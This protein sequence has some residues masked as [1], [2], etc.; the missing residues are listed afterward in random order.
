[1]D[2]ERGIVLVNAPLYLDTQD[3]IL[4]V[5][6]TDDGLPHLSDEAI[7]YVKMIRNLNPPFITSNYTEQVSEYANIGHRVVRVTATDADPPNSPSGQL[8]YDLAPGLTTGA[9]D[10][11]SIGLMGEP[12][13]I[14]VNKTLKEFPG[15]DMYFQVIASDSGVPPKSA[16]SFVHVKYVFSSCTI[17]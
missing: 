6:A 3:Y 13:L 5:V 12:G 15:N 11:F 14:T 17:N 1:M 10:Y 9:T 16:I 8:N 4:T 2:A 7:L